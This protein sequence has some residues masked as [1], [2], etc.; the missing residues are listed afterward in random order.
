MYAAC[1][2]ILLGV[3]KTT[4]TDLCLIEIGL[5]SLA[6]YVRNAQKKA[7]SRLVRQR[8]D[9]PDDPFMHALR[10]AR[11]SRCPI[12]RYVDLLETFNAEDEMS[13]LYA[14][15]Q[16][17]TRT[18]FLTY[19]QK[20][21][22]TLTVHDM[23]AATDIREAERITATRIRLSSHNLAIERGRWSRL[24]PENRLCQC[25]EI[26]DENHIAAVCPNYLYV[27]FISC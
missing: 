6:Q 4:A 5:P 10:I 1:V 21:N 14:R 13:D 15:V 25:G 24:P 26:Q 12:T 16:Q 18:K 19:T 2:T 11:Q 23:Y 8:A 17:S 22:P 7:L 20:I 27:T 9:L 3:R